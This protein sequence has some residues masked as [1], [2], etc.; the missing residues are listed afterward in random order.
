MIARH[1][2]KAF[3]AILTL[4]LIALAQAAAP[5]KH[6]FIALDEG[7]ENLLYVNQN[8]STKNWLVSISSVYPARDLQLIGNNRLLL[9]HNKGYNEYNLTTGAVV[10]QLL[11][12]DSVTSVRRLPN[13]QTVLFGINPGGAGLFMVKLDSNNVQL[14]KTVF[15]GNYIRLV[16]QTNQGTFLMACNDSIFE[17]DTAIT[18]ATG[19]YI[20]KKYVRWTAPLNANETL[21]HMW[22][23]VRL[24]NGHLF[25][26]GGYAAFMA[27]IDTAGNFIDTIGEAPQ[28]AGVEPYFYAMFQRFAN[29]H[30]VVANWEGHGAGRD[31]TG[32]VHELIE[33]DSL[34]N[35]VWTW[36]N[37]ALISSLQEVLVLDSLNTNLL[38]DDRDGIMKPLTATAVLPPA[39]RAPDAKS[40]GE[41]LPLSP[42]GRLQLFDLLG[43]S[44]AGQVQW[45]GGKAADVGAGMYIL[46]N[47]AGSWKYPQLRN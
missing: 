26:S 40:S 32:K 11:T 33:F 47:S 27:E 7:L 4:S 44:P 25:L 5:I 10:R 12:Y 13:G 38:Y 18:G 21:M 19:K 46:K 16:R 29:G 24:D 31:T 45:T 37:P 8:D 2:L 42:E 41:A 9:A 15:P 36:D 30:V 23:V 34:R 17:A 6:Q 43:R 39:Y 35:I 14:G 1:R 20:W 28:P 3:S 22:K